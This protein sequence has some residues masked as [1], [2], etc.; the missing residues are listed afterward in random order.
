M[1]LTNFN[2]KPKHKSH[3]NHSRKEKKTIKLVK[4]RRR[5][6]KSKMNTLI[7]FI[8]DVRISRRSYSKIENHLLNLLVKKV[9]KFLKTLQ[10]KLIVRAPSDTLAKCRISEVSCAVMWSTRPSSETCASS[11]AKSSTKLP[12]L[13]PRR[14][15]S[16]DS[17]SS[18]VSIST[19]TLTSQ[20]S[21]QLSLRETPTSCCSYPPTSMT[22]SFSL[23]V[24]STPKISETQWRGMEKMVKKMELRKLRE[25]T[26]N[27]FWGEDQ[28]KS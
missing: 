1:N 15:T 16:P 25:L 18:A 7:W 2:H 23:A 6:L 11:L 14:R 21:S 12:C 28:G 27:S 10:I 19:S 9:W 22:S 26:G 17:S 8:I 4:K 3:L 20:S 24:S 5:N 13:R